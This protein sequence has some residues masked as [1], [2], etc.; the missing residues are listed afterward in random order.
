MQILLLLS[1]SEVTFLLLPSQN[2]TPAECLSHLLNVY[3]TI[4]LKEKGEESFL[5]SA[6]IKLGVLNIC[7]LR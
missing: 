2:F 6:R 4:L 3:P 1:P 5:V 7:A